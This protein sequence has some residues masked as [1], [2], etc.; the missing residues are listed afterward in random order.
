VLVTAVG[1]SHPD[2]NA[3][4]ATVA[5]EVA[6]T[7]R[8]KATTA[9]VTGPRPGLADAAASLRA[10]G[11]TRLIVAPWFLAHG[12]LTDRIADFA[13]AHRIPMSAPLGAHRQVAATVLDRYDAALSRRLA[14]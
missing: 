3:R 9:F 10:R 7:T 1:S 14:A 2:A 8:W 11:A 4:T 12:R 13:A 5:R 6:L